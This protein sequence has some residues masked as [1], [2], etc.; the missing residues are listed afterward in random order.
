MNPLL[1]VISVIALVIG[2]ALFYWNVIKTKPQEVK[3]AAPVA[4]ERCLKDEDEAYDI[5]RSNG[6]FPFTNKHR[7]SCKHC[8][9]LILSA[10]TMLEAE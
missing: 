5:L 4:N 8:S 1:V 2:A 3:F 10:K 9:V 6:N 7:T